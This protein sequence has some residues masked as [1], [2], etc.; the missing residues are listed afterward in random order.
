MTDSVQCRE[1]GG[2]FPR[3]PGIPSSIDV[4]AAHTAIQYLDVEV[5]EEPRTVTVPCGA[6]AVQKV[7]RIYH[8]GQAAIFAAVD[9]WSSELVEDVPLP[10]ED[11]LHPDQLVP[12]STAARAPRG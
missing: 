9:L 8:L 7:R 1:C 3:L 6:A 2:D 4:P 5:G 11:E 12:A 10:A